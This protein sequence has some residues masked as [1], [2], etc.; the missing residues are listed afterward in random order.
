MSDIAER[1]KTPIA[2][3]E[4]E[5][6]W[7]AVRA[8][9]TERQIDVLLMQ[10]NND[11]MG[12]YVKYFTDVP[13][14]T[15][16]PITVVFPK[17]DLMTVVVQGDFGMKQD[18]PPEGDGVYRGV[19]RVVGAP[20]FASVHYTW[21][22]DAELAEKALESFGGATIGLVGLATLPLSMMDRLH[23]GRL[24]N[25]K[26]V[27][28]T[29]LVDQIKCI[30]SDEEFAMIRQTAA[31]Q[32]KAIEAVF[33]A[34]KPGKRD[35]EIAA[36]AEHVILNGGGEQALLLT[37]SHAPGEPIYWNHRH[38]QNRVLRAG[39][40][41]SL[42][43][44]TNGPGGF[45]TEISRTCVLGKATQAM[46]DEFAFLLETRKFTLDRLIPGASCLDIWDSYNAFLK[47]N[48]RPEENRLYCHGQGYDL[49]ERPLVRKDEPMRI[50]ANMNLT[51]HPTWI[52]SGIFNTICDNFL[53]GEKGVVGR[54]HQSPETLI[55]L[56]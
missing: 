46:K 8:A 50:H 17:D 14:L 19:K 51:C 45:Y 35:I 53:I 6:R 1:V 37:C 21:A 52:R 26:F 47:R 18:L 32:D 3:K 48:G 54:I 16:Y 28:A 36:V 15:G 11:F 34:V 23:K 33:K 56:G 5:R 41:F 27:D 39:D 30:K 10:N 22:Y 2:T 40:M 24:S 9:M 31:L 20:Y 49:V 42:L 25:A 29:D 12:G 38:L 4:L 44:E 13:A 43:V 55:E 7:K